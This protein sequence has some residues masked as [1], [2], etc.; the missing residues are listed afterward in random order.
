M[1]NSSTVLSHHTI[2]SDGPLV[3]LLPGAGDLRSEY[4]ALETELATA[5]FRVVAADLPGHGDSPPAATYGVAE[6]ADALLGL[7]RHLDAGPAVVV[8]TSF[9]PAAAI[10]AAA[11]SSDAI[12]GLVAISAHM[13]ADDSIRSR[14]QRWSV[15]AL[16]RG[17]LAA[18]VWDRLY[19]SW[20]KASAPDDL[21][22]ELAAMRRMLSRPEGRRAVR[23]TLVAGREGVAQRMDSFDLPA[24]VVFGSADDHFT[25]PADEARRLGETL[26]APVLMVE[27][28]GHYPHVEQPETVAGA[29]VDFL[30]GV[31]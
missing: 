9:A 10:W 19:R 18:P 3:V 17:R 4:R 21:D 7:I 20:Y 2:G 12:R 14:L 31:A 11:T 5:G 13:E 25:D 8:A 15:L 1:T 26:G 28:A 24:L 16:L 27:G 30:H 22:I 29:V 23:E 6:T